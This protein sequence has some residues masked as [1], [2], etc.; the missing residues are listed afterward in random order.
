MMAGGAHAPNDSV[1]P[2]EAS[3]LLMVTQA[4]ERTRSKPSLVREGVKRTWGY[5]SK[6]AELSSE[7][8][9]GIFYGSESFSCY[10]F[11]SLAAIPS[12]FSKSSHTARKLLLMSLLP[13]R[14]TDIP[15]ERK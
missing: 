13:Y 11:I 9:Y 15:S 14:F 2:H 1:P 6:K 8:A 7:D 3:N 5:L 12:V 10:F 4:V